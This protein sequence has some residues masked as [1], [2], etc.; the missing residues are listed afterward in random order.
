[1]QWLRL[2]FTAAIGILGSVGWGVKDEVAGP[3]R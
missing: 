2:G 1:M 3:G